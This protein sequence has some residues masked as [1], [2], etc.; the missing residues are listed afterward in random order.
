MLVLRHCPR[1][2][3]KTR[4]LDLGQPRCLTCGV[5]YPDEP[6][7]TTEPDPNPDEPTYPLADKDPPAPANV[8]LGGLPLCPRCHR[9]VGMKE[10]DCG[11]CGFLF[12]DGVV[13]PLRRDRMPH[14]GI[15]IDQ[16]GAVALIG[17]LMA[18][19]LG[20]LG[21][22]LTVSTGLP[23]WLMARHDLPRMDT[24]EVDPQGR[25]RTEMG[26]WTSLWGLGLGVVL[27]VGWT[28]VVIH[29]LS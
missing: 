23:A 29:W 13:I 14:R 27:T 9:P 18:G 4:V 17:G 8:P 21:L 11:W 24:G 19:L 25:A 26:R 2:N 10:R 6:P 22:A 28:L 5:V 15:L 16:L 7:P 12:D 3:I 1:C 20:P